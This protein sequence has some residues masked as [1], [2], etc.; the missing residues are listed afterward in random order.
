V[1]GWFRAGS[2]GYIT[3]TY[4]SSAFSTSCLCP[5]FDILAFSLTLICHYDISTQSHPHLPV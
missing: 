3:K 5:K 4:Q 2:G 1:W